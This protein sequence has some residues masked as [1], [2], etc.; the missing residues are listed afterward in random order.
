MLQENIALQE[1]SA[2]GEQNSIDALFSYNF[3]PFCVFLSRHLATERPWRVGLSGSQASGMLSC[4]FRTCAGEGIRNLQEAEEFIRTSIVMAELNDEGAYGKAMSGRRVNEL[5]SAGIPVPVHSVARLP[6]FAAMAV[7]DRHLGRD[8]PHTSGVPVPAWI[9]VGEAGISLDVHVQPGASS[10]EWCGQYSPS[11]AKVR[12][13]T[14]PEDGKAN[15]A[16]LTF[17]AESM[18][19]DKSAVSLVRGRSSREK[20]VEIEGITAD[21]ALRV[22]G[23]E[24]E[25]PEARGPGLQLQ[26]AIDAA[27]GKAKD[28]G[29]C[30]CSDHN[31]EHEELGTAIRV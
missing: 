1:A 8:S 14:R 23:Y 7:E 19:V 2:I 31:H 24:P 21:H 27:T 28:P 13:A 26:S 22:V 11:R 29:A 4:D 12:I 3:V 25:L 16:L 9:R 20:T 6:V 18:A 15:T 17:V 10:T 30:G 5:A